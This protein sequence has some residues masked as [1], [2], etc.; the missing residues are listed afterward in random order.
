MLLTL[1]LLINPLIESPASES[2]LQADDPIVVHEISETVLMVEGFGGNTTVVATPEGVFLVDSLMQPA[3]DALN[4]LIEARFGSSPRAMVNTHHHGDHSVGNDVFN[5]G[6]TLTIAHSFMRHRIA[7]RR[8]SDVSQRWVEPRPVERL[9]VV[10]YED[11]MS[12]FWGD[13]AIRIYH[14]AAAHTGGDSIVQVTTAN[15]IATG[16]VF[17]NGIWPIID[18]YAGGSV[19]GTIA[20]LAEIHR[21]ADENTVII[22][23]HGPL[24]SREEVLALH[25]RL[26]RMRDITLAALADDMSRAAFIE[27]DPLQAVAPEWQE[28]FI[29]SRGL[30]GAFY[31]DLSADN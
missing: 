20:A 22:P 14:P 15:I 9:P 2:P 30:A 4:S 24:A 17:V 3:S 1:M 10:V 21:L 29:D 11:E 18:V 6:G 13:E 16:D 7:H 5:N 8:Y 27:S 12:L 23:G 31:D 19:D 25:D 28:W 26:I